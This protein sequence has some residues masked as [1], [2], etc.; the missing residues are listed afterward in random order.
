VHDYAGGVAA[1]DGAADITLDPASGAVWMAHHPVLG[2][3]VLPS[4]GQVRYFDGGGASRWNGVS[5]RSWTK[6]FA[7][8]QLFGDKGI[9]ESILVDRRAGLVWLGGWDGDPITFHWG[10]GRDVDASLNWCPVDDCTD[11]AWSARVWPD[12]GTVA[13]L[14][15]D[16]E[17]RVWAGTNRA[18]A[19]LAPAVAG[20]KL[21]AAGEW[22]EVTTANSGLVDDEVSA[23]AADGDRMWVGTLSQGVSLHV[24]GARPTPTPPATETAT[25]SATS[26]A[27]FTDEPTATEGA[28]ATASTRPTTP[29]APTPTSTRATGCQPGGRCTVLL[30]LAMG[31]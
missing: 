14:A 28:T 11:G 22:S 20:V 30:P 29:D 21:L 5:W 25:A 16:A 10:L 13:A 8:L 6:P 31:R 27:V 2:Y 12:D 24:P 23:L 7:P 3:T 1:G 15:V 19:G 4:G 17:G 9:A 26:S 18:E